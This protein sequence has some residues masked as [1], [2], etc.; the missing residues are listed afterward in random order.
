MIGNDVVALA[1]R[2]AAPRAA[3]PR[4]VGRVLHADEYAWWAGQPDPEAA[5][6]TLWALKESA[7]KREFRRW[8]RRFFAPK[9]YVCS[10]LPDSPDLQ[11]RTPRGCYVGRVTPH[12]AYLHA[13]VADSARQLDALRWACVAWTGTGPQACSRAVRAIATQGLRAQPGWET[14]VVGTHPHHGFPVGYRPG[15]PGEI[16]LSLSHDGPW[17]AYAFLPGEDSN[18]LYP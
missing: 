15:I 10:P 3:N 18:A 2:R 12:Q 16:P 9:Q 8:P 17:A 1:E 14:A 6:W 13:V 5:L 7:Y 4:F 11:V